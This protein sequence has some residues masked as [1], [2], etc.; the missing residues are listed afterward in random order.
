MQRPIDVLET[1]LGTLFKV[2]RLIMGALMLVATAAIAVAVLVFWL[3]FRMRQKEFA[4]LADIG[5][6]EGTLRM[7][8]AWEI[9]L[10]GAG[11]VV[12]A[13][14]V[15]GAAAALAHG[16]FLKGLLVS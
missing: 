11:A 16:W 9:C 8:R 6:S 1:L 3:S 10:V 4:T 2:E 15:R 5:V 7:V 14:L 13:I 12:V